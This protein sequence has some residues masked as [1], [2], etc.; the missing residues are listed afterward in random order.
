MEEIHLGLVL[1]GELEPIGTGGRTQEGDLGEG[2][3]LDNI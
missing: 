1:V 2:V 3:S